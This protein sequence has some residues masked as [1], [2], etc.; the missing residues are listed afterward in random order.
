MDLTNGNRISFKVLEQF[1][2]KQ[3][4]LKKLILDD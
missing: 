1:R 3:N 4:E 2:L